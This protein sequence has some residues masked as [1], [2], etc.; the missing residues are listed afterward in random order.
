MGYP[1]STLENVINKIAKNSGGQEGMITVHAIK[2][3]LMQ[4][5]LDEDKKYYRNMNYPFK[6]ILQHALTEETK[7]SEKEKEIKLQ[8]MYSK[9]MGTDVEQRE[10][11][12]GRNRSSS[13]K[14]DEDENP[15]QEM[16]FKDDRKCRFCVTSYLRHPGRT[17]IIDHCRAQWDE[18]SLPG[19]HYFT[20]YTPTSSPPTSSPTKT[21]PQNTPR[22]EKI[23]SETRHPVN[24]TGLSDAENAYI[25]AKSLMAAKK[26]S[27]ALDYLVEYREFVGKRDPGIRH[28]KQD[29][30]LLYLHT[31]SVQ[32]RR[33]TQQ[34]EQ[35]FSKIVSDPATDWEKL[36]NEWQRNYG[37]AGVA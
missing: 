9:I 29:R 34:E 36:W 13:V 5:T 12:G 28:P 8:N 27:M 15:S 11:L 6:L 25:T 4:S 18:N 16:E 32:L 37:T 1:L 24:F 23:F 3:F 19:V 20:E 7:K 30:H 22:S 14:V 10:A 2:Q 31:C 26:W 35:D 33:K 21:S 17:C